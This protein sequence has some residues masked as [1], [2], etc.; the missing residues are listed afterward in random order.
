MKLNRNELQQALQSAA[1]GL[2]RKRIVP[3]GDCVVFR[4]NKI[5]TYNGEISC[6]VNFQS[7]IDGAIHAELL[8]AALGR[9]DADEITAEVTESELLL[10]AG[11]R[12]AGIVF[13]QEVLLPI[14][15]IEQPGKWKKVTPEFTQAVAMAVG[16]CGENSSRFILNCIH[17]SGHYIEAADPYQVIRCKVQENFSESTLIRGS[18]AKC[19]RDATGMHRSPNWIH[20]LQADGSVIS[21]RLYRDEYPAIEGFF[22]VDGEQLK[23]PQELDTIVNRAAVFCDKDTDDVRR[24]FVLLKAGKMIIEARTVAAWYREATDISYSG[25]P[26]RFAIDP[27]LL[28]QLIKLGTDSIV[29]KDRLLVASEVFQYATCL[30]VVE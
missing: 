15:S 5:I 24:V 21:C 26:L 27:K 30:G 25:P 12:K 20:F 16:C 8:S 18:A 9:F 28:S 17:F 2:D 19:I 22:Q 11:R 14:D 3:Q 10:K 6:S 7:E 4:D 29:N 13:Q 23:L 1:M